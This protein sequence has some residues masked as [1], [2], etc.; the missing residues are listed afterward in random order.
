MAW[1]MVVIDECVDKFDKIQVLKF[2]AMKTGHK[3][4]IGSNDTG[5]DAVHLVTIWHDFE[6]G[7][8]RFGKNPR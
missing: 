5:D 8:V 7:T 4:A 3:L 6:F 2:E 1:S